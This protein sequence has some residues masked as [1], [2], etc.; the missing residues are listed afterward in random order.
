MTLN[1]GSAYI[2]LPLAMVT[3]VCLIGITNAYAFEIN[4][5]TV[6]PPNGSSDFDLD[7]DC[8]LALH[9]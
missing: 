5:A 7:S 8:P 2:L 4:T 9:E 1:L 3:L 6:S